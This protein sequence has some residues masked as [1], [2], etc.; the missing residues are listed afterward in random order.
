VRRTRRRTVYIPRGTVV[1]ARPMSLPLRRRRR[2]V[3]SERLSSLFL[4][5]A[6]AA[7]IARPLVPSRA[8]RPRQ[9]PSRSTAIKLYSVVFLLTARRR[10]GHPPD[11]AYA[12][13][14]S[15]NPI[16]CCFCVSSR[17]ARVRPFFDQSL[18]SDRDSRAVVERSSRGNGGASRAVTAEHRGAV[19][20]HIMLLLLYA[21]L[22]HVTHPTRCN[23]IVG[24]YFFTA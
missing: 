17:V 6:A 11:S 14:P 5:P 23:I 16:L 7:I 18:Q 8:H 3:A 22:S 9:R 10:Q 1:G 19:T 4:S 15:R 21:Y 12:L 2:R 24:N 20:M 13:P